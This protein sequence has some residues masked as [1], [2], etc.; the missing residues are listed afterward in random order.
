[1]RGRKIEEVDYES[2]E[3]AK[4]KRLIAEIVLSYYRDLQLYIQCP[5]L[6]E[7]RITKYDK[8][9]NENGSGD[10]FLER[11]FIPAHHVIEFWNNDAKDFFKFLYGAGV[12][13][14]IMGKLSPLINKANKIYEERRFICILE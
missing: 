3:L 7:K 12:T 5:E 9:E 10:N 11:G 6:F 8:E 4:I 14:R 2:V 13:E 1:M